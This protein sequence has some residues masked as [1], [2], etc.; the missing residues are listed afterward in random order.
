LA[1]EAK[2]KGNEA[3]KKK[4]WC[5]APP[6]VCELS[7]PMPGATGDAWPSR[8]DGC[9]VSPMQGD[10]NRALHRR[11]YARRLEPSVLREP[12]LRLFEQRRYATCTLFAACPDG[13]VP[14]GVV[15]FGT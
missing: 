9:S 14:K 8:C 6:D 15:L 2:L 7:W 1:E 13:A 3:F 11:H 10:V 4:E 5:A 12:Q